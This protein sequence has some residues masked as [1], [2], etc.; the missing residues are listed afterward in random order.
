MRYK[1]ALVV[2]VAVLAGCATVSQMEATGGSR[3]DGIVKLSFEYGMFDK[4]ALDQS[5]GLVKA[6]QRCAVWGYTDADP[7]GGIVRQCQAMSGYGCTHWF[8][9]VE[10]QCTMG[11]GAAPALTQASAPFAPIGTPPM[12]VAA[13]GPRLVHAKTASGYCLDVPRDYVGTGAENSPAVSSG[14]PRCDQLSAK[15]DDSSP[16]RRGR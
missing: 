12:P 4:V 5:A 6:R 7:F 9:T 11:G 15:G 13:S 16:L 2:T 3:S 8:A 10:Y 14:M 1:L